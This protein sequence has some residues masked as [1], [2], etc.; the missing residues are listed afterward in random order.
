MPEIKH[1]GYRREGGKIYACITYKTS[2]YDFRIQ[3]EANMFP[4]AGNVYETFTENGG[5]SL[6]RLKHLWYNP[7][8]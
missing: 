7:S 4:P 6:Q 3:M 2:L 8:Q 1:V 5:I